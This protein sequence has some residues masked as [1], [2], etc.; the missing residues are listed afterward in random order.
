MAVEEVGT[1]FKIDQYLYLLFI[2][3]RLARSYG[4]SN[5]NRGIKKQ[6]VA[7]CNMVF[8]LLYFTLFYAGN[9]SNCF[10]AV[11]PNLRFI[12]NIFREAS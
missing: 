7:F 3:L 4:G 9:L 5:N 12:R 6:S 10:Y 8:K 11:V 1:I 2:S